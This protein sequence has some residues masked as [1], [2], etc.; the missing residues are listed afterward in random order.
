MARQIEKKWIADGAIDGSKIQLLEGQSIV[1]QVAGTPVELLK[2]NENG[3]ATLPQ[4]EVPNV[5]YVDDSIAEL[6]ALLEQDIADRIAAVETELDQEVLDRQAGDSSTLTS[7]N[8]YTDAQIAAIPPVDLTPYETIVNVDAKILLAQGYTDTKIAQEVSRATDAEQ[9]IAANLS[10]ET[11]ARQAADTALSNDIT[12][13]EGVVQGNFDLQQTDIDL[14]RSDI[15]ALSTSASSLQSQIDTEKG[16]ID[17]ILQASEVDKDT[18]AEVISLINSIDTENDSAFA[19][20]TLSNDA[21]VGEVE[22]DLAQEILDRQAGDSQTLVDA[23]AY[24]DAQIAAIPPVDLTPYYTKTEVD[25]IEDGLVQDISDLDVYAQDLRTDLDTLDVYAQNIRGDVDAQ[26]TRIA[27]LEAQTDGPSFANGS[28]L[29]ET[30]LTFVDLDR[31]YIK[32]MSC[33]VDRMAVHEGEDYTVSVVGGKT[34]L[35]WIN[36]LAVGGLEAIETGDKVFFVGA[37]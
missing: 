4:G 11:S 18:F 6:Q 3:N 2:L 30:E 8:E 1:I 36:S 17:A 10:T 5:N 16:R 7:A 29:V 28:V 27:A 14:I 20:Y 22:S 34:R 26:E 23:K 25:A 32:L 21:R 37:Y 12:A 19:G 33:S 31:Q 15:D 24:T 35:T 9:Q 13:L